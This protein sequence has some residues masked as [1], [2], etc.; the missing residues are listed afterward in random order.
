MMLT[1]E[2]KEDV[3]LVGFFD[4]LLAQ[5]PRHTYLDFLESF[6]CKTVR[7]ELY[8]YVI[9]LLVAHSHPELRTVLFTIA[10][11]EQNAHRIEIL[12]SAFAL[13]RQDPV[14]T[15]LIQELQQ[16]RRLQSKGR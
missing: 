15:S 8:Q 12:L 6:L 3:E 5:T 7:D 14:V 9:A 2:T 13:I 10:R 11:Q 4:L 16:R 1:Y